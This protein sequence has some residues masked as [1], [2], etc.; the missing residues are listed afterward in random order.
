MNKKVRA[1]ARVQLTIEIDGE[2]GVWG[3]ECSLDQVHKQAREGAIGALNRVVSRAGNP[4]AEK[5]PLAR[6]AIRIIGE[7][8]V[9]AILVEEE[10]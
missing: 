10:R 1:T 4:E 2:G 7:P 6:I 9:T 5:Q 8:K 3:A